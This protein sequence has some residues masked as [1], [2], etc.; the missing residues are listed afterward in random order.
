VGSRKA[1]EAMRDEKRSTGTVLRSAA[2]LKALAFDYSST[3]QRVLPPG[4]GPCNRGSNSITGSYG[5]SFAFARRTT[6]LLSRVVASGRLLI[7]RRLLDRLLDLRTA[8]RPL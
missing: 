6:G 2:L 8:R 4:S 1:A 7:M 3:R 5:S